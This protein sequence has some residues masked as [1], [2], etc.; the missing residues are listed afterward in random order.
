MDNKHLWTAVIAGG[1]GTR[2][3]PVSYPGR[4]KQ[5]CQ[6]ND[7]DTFIQAVIGN[8]VS[9]GVRPCNI[10]VITT[11]K[12]QTRH[13]RKQTQPRGILSQDIY[14]IDPE[15]G[16]PG[17]MYQATKFIHDIDPDAVIIN[18]PSDQYLEATDDD[19]AY[20]VKTAVEEANNGNPTLIGVKVNDLHVAMGCGHAIY[21]DTDSGCYTVTD[22][23]E[24]PDKKTAD[25]VM[26]RD[27]AACNTGIVVWKADALLDSINEEEVRGVGTD[28]FLKKFETLKIAVGSFAWKDCGTFNSL[29][30][31]S[32][33]TPHHHNASLGKG[34]FERI[35]CLRSMFYASEGMELSVSDAEDELVVFTTID[36][37]PV[38]V[39]ADLKEVEGIK[40]L[41]ELYAEHGGFPKGIIELLGASGNVV[42]SS[43]ISKELIAIFI[44]VQ[45]RA[46]YAEEKADS[47]IRCSV[48]KQLK[49]S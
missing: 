44:G 28:E 13:A 5:F 26:R 15:W 27:D 36:D 43:N 32:K 45:N 10:V 40:M 42:L 24:K 48:G 21:E 37:R 47:K 49:A 19:F 46:V 8:F 16:Y 25:F 23:L 34:T 11:N 17:A 38:V 41:A 6:L 20:T 7:K 1:E 39:V 14:Q 4:P 3:F 33:K 31:V 12:A 29:F 18:T 35:R 9:I 30:E 22:F 2:L